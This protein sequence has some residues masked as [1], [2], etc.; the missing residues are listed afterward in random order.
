VAPVPS[1]ELP[2]VDVVLPPLTGADGV[3]TG[4]DICARAPKAANANPLVKN[5]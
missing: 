5:L 1:A 4:V 2:V 3:K